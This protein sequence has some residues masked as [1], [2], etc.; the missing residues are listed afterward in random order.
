M[1]SVIAQF[2]VALAS[3]SAP[4]AEAADNITMAVA[5]DKTAGGGVGVLMLHRPSLYHSAGGRSLSSYSGGGGSRGLISASKCPTNP[6][7][8]N[9]RSGLIISYL[10]KFNY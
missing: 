6:S 2:E 7:P 10:R 8:Y 9:L 4:L 1:E 3:N 5:P